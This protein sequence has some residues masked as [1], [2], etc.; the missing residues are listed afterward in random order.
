MGVE[1]TVEADRTEVFP[2]FF[3]PSSPSLLGF[4]SVRFQIPKRGRESRIAEKV[5]F[6]WMAC[7]NQV[8]R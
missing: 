4:Q 2:I 3:L 7:E 1:F 6:V 5:F 8:E